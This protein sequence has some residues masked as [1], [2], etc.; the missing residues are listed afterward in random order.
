MKWFENKLAYSEKE[1]SKCDF[2]ETESRF[3]NGT[4]EAKNAV[5]VRNAGF[6][7][8]GEK[9]KYGK[10]WTE[11]H[12]FYGKF[13]VRVGVNTQPKQVA[14]PSLEKEAPGKR[15]FLI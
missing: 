8:S 15:R 4:S 11:Q 14:N 2:Y 1:D 12:G 6:W 3:C 9:L 7:K 13:L 10:N 5:C